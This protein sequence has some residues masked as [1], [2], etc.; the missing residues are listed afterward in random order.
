[1]RGSFSASEIVCML[2]CAI[3]FDYN[4]CQSSGVCTR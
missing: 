4:S 1:M 2:S 3:V